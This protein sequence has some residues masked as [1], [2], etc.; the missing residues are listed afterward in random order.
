MFSHGSAMPVYGRLEEHFYFGILLRTPFQLL[1][2]T[3]VL[4]VKVVNK[5]IPV[6]SAPKQA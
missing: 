4:P 6:Q 2:K 5:T 1:K 3:K